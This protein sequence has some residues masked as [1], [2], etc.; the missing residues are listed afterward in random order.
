MATIQTAF[1]RVDG[2]G[3]VAISSHAIEF[4]EHLEDMIVA[5]PDLLGPDRL[6]V[7]DRQVLT[8]HG[9]RLDLLAIDD[10]AL[11]HAIE[12]KRDQTPRE[13]VAQ[14]LDYGYGGSEP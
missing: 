4:E 2:G 11:L 5:E 9:K 6:L 7:I 12:L 3:P 10:Q 14:A 13:V 8:S 1:W